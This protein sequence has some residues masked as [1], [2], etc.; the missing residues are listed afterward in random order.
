VGA[1]VL[2]GCVEE[3]GHIVAHLRDFGLQLDVLPLQLLRLLAILP[4]LPSPPHLGLEFGAFVDGLKGGFEPARRRFFGVVGLD[5][6]VL[7]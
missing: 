7:P 2:V 6:K 3:L 4:I 5:C 1:A